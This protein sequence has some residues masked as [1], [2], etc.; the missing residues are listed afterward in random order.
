VQISASEAFAKRKISRFFVVFVSTSV[1]LK[2]TTSITPINYTLVRSGNHIQN[3][4]IVRAHT[5]DFTTAAASRAFGPDRAAPGIMR[6]CIKIIQFH[7]FFASLVFIIVPAVCGA[8]H[9]VWVKNGDRAFPVAGC[10]L[11]NSLPPDV[12]SASTLT[13]FR[14]RLKT[15]LFSRSF[16]S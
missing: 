10:R 11:W 8:A 9:E 4:Q 3:I 2:K 6:L 1:T 7:T 14:N 13:V 15:Y 16:P 12:T 5:R